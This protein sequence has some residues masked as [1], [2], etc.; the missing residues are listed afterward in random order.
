MAGPYLITPLKNKYL[1]TIIDH[2]TKHVEAFQIPDQ[3]AEACP[4]VYATQIV[5]R[6]GTESTLITDQGSSFMSSFFK[7]ICRILGIRKVNTSSYHPS[8][9]GI[10]KRLHRSLHSGLSYYIDSANTNWHI[11]V[12]FYLMSY[13]ATPNTTT[14]FS[15]YYLLHGREMA[16]P[17]SDNL[18]AKL[19]KEKKVWIRIAD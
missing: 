3:T 17:N 10:V 11:V 2:F 1:L 4:R 9:N 6:H 12:P 14:G 15:P 13:R 18:K 5:T 8:S 7:E 16:L 19:S